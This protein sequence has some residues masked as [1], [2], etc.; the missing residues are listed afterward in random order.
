MANVKH[1][2]HSLHVSRMGKEEIKQGKNIEATGLK[3]LVDLS[4]QYNE[5]AL[6]FQCWESFERGNL[7]ENKFNHRPRWFHCGNEFT[8]Q[9]RLELNI[10]NELIGQRDIDTISVDDPDIL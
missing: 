2:H 3:Y 8:I 1:Y 6:C 9:L 5:F 7:S 4:E 10:T